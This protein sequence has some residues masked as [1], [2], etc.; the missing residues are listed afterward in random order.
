VSDTS[1]LDQISPEQFAEMVAGAGDDDIAKA[2]HAVGTAA[3]LDRIFAGMQE[4]FRPDKAS[5]VDADIQF[6]VTDEGEEH[7][8]RVTI[9]DA[10]CATGRGTAPDPKVTLTADIVPFSRLITG[11]ASGPQLFMAGKLKV[12]GDIFFS[13]RI[14]SFFDQPKS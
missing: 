13:Q 5:G 12:S 1:G 2:V 4:R 7:L 11:D 10:S 9:K 6:V 3:T 8:Y 14:T